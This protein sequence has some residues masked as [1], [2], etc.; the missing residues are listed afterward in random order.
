MAMSLTV[1]GKVSAVVGAAA[2]CF[3]GGYWVA[4]QVYK[5]EIA[6][7]VSDYERRSKVAQEEQNAKLLAER[8]KNAKTT[9]ELLEKL[10]DLSVR[11]RNASAIAD[12]LQ[13]ELANR[14]KVSRSESG[15]CRDCEERS[16][17]CAE[18]LAEGIGLADEGRG[19]AERIAIRKDSL[20]NFRETK[21]KQ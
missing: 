5:R 18:L 16:A 20:V 11:Q 9:S 6:D 14:A 21:G 13:R 4:A 19:L 3:V 7:M 12:R 15:S 1:W 17:R 2:V 10:N 8:E